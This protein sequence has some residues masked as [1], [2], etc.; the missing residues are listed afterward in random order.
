MFIIHWYFNFH[1]FS[2]HS[3]DPFIIQKCIL[4]FI[5]SIY[6]QLMYT[7]THFV[8]CISLLLV[9]LFFFTYVFVDV[10]LPQ[11]K[12]V[13]LV[14]YEFFSLTLYAFWIWYP[15]AKVGITSVINPLFYCILATICSYSTT[16]VGNTASDH[17]ARCFSRLKGV[18]CLSFHLLYIS[19][20]PLAILFI[21]LCSCWA[22]LTNHHSA[23][24]HCE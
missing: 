11:V 5:N 12:N 18:Y 24:V 3:V 8:V 2:G 9:G 14:K 20:V 17:Q 21:L 6:T 19:R 4:T 15:N 13:Y 10:L 1:K 22:I 23:P 7:Y 16:H